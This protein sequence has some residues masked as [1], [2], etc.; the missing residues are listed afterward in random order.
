VP[1]TSAPSLGGYGEYHLSGGLLGPVLD[2]DGNPTYG[3]YRAWRDG[4]TG[5]FFHSGGS[6][7]VADLTLARQEEATAITR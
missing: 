1:C 2:P 4:C 5:K 7:D 3:A 6:V